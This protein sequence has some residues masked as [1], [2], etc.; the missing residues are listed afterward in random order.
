MLFNIS[1]GVAPSSNCCCISSILISSERIL[2]N[3]LASTDLNTLVPESITFSLIPCS[4]NNSLF[5]SIAVAISS[6]LYFSLKSLYA[7]KTS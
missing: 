2:F 3:C 4:V 5:S 6:L 7:C 1:V